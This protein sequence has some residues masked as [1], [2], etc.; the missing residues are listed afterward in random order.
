MLRRTLPTLYVSQRKRG[1]RKSD[2]TVSGQEIIAM[3][4]M[5]EMAVVKLETTEL[6]VLVTTFCTPP[7]SFESRD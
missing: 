5:V 2:N 1:S 4:T 7:T 6:A 3:A